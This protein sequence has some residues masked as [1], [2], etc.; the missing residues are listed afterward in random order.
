V[1][2]K[3]NVIVPRHFTEKDSARFHSEKFHHVSNSERKELLDAGAIVALGNSG[4]VFQF[5]TQSLARSNY[6]T[7]DGRLSLEIPLS[8]QSLMFSDMRR[9]PSWQINIL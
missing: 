8:V 1:S 5:T 3:S 6:E 7:G 9:K 2:K 4:R